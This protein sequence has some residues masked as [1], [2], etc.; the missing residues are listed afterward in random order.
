MKRQLVLSVLVFLALV[1][2]G[3][4]YRKVIAS[5]HDDGENDAKA[6]ALNL[7][8]HYVFKDPNDATKLDLVMYV[9]PRSLPGYQYHFSTL[10][11]YQF[12]VG[13]ITNKANAA[14]GA[15]D[16]IFRFE[17]SAADANNVQSGTFTVV[18]DGS[19]VG[20]ASG[21]TTTIGNSKA[22]TLTTNSSTV[23][24]VTYTWFAGPRQ[25]TFHFDVQRFFQVRAFAA[26]RF[27][28]GSGGIGDPTA[29]LAANCK[30][31]AFLGGRTVFGGAA[32]ADGDDIR[33]FNKPSCAPD[34]THKYNVTAIVLQVPI[35]ALQSS[36]AE[37]AFDT[38]STI[39]I[40]Q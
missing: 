6:R 18:K 20:T 37:T 8:D 40:P 13:R 35:S 4:G 11:R 14:T 12:H 17:F 1:G 22:G 5:D 7:T 21:S 24:G 39:S 36:A 25:D 10:A 9:N 34:F 32:D 15:T 2:A 33:L 23:G 27:Y 16:L 29:S 30:G 26:Q 38:W 19:V 31:E 28:G 3:L